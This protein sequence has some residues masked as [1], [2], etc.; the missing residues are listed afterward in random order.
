MNA[1]RGATLLLALCALAACG[2]DGAPTADVAGQ[3]VPVPVA[4]VQVSAQAVEEPIWATGTLEADKQVDIGPRVDGIIDQVF[5]D[6]GDRV[7]VGDEL[8]R[9]RDTEYQIRVREAEHALQLARAETKKASHELERAEELFR[10]NIVSIEAIE[11]VR[12]AHDTARARLGQAQTALERA[13]Q[14]FEDTRV[15]APF[16]GSITRRFVDEGVMLRTMLSSGSAVVQLMKLDQVVAVARLPDVHLARIRPGTQARLHVDGFEGTFEGEVQVVSDRVDPGSR[17]LEVRV[18]IPNPELA[19]KPGLF[20][21][22]EVRPEPRR[23]LVIER[24]ALRGH[25]PD[26]YVLV[27]ENGR[28]ARRN[29][30]V[31]NLDAQH[32]EILSGLDAGAQLLVARPGSELDEGAAFVPAADAPL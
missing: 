11:S 23:A 20:A 28:A 22:L 8:F 16:A 31:R 1:P 32:V 30:A 3:P 9:T 26:A 25:A 2:G 18:P 12:T 4:V 14:E 27:A 17:T 15:R 10:G 24:R 13:R 29:V 5:V 19:L 21:K 7:A 6:V